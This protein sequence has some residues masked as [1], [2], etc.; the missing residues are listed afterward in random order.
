MILLMGGGVAGV[1]YGLVVIRRI[2]AVQL[3]PDD[4]AFYMAL[5]VLAYVM[6]IAGA[7]MSPAT[8]SFEL[9]GAALVL[10]LIVGMRNTWDMANFAITR[11]PSQ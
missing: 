6:M 10:L 7:L 8:I 4:W 3:S 11:D 9:V 5:P 1:V 2:W